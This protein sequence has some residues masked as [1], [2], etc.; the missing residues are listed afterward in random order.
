ME[1]SLLNPMSDVQK[2][3]LKAGDVVKHI[4]NN[5][6]VYE[7]FRGFAEP[8]QSNPTGI[9]FFQKQNVLRLYNPQQ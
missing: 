7:I 9:Q 8:N 1:I 2:R 6:P 4:V 5:R 3:N